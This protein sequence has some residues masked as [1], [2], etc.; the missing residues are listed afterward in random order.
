VNQVPSN[1]GVESLKDFERMQV[2]IRKRMVMSVILNLMIKEEECTHA[3]PALK[4]GQLLEY[5]LLLTEEG[6]LVLHFRHC[7]S[8]SSL[9]SLIVPS[10][11]MWKVE[12]VEL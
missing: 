4:E 11:E 9:F 8:H 3:H 2:V 5:D 12:V 6:L 7:F 10:R 1:N